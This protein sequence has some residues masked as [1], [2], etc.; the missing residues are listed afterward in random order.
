MLGFWAKF[1]SQV[2]IPNR[3]F[4]GISSSKNNLPRKVVTLVKVISD[5]VDS[6]RNLEK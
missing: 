2:H 5:N 4:F 3:V 6:N 1:T